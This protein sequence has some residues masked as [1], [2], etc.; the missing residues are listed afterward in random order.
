MGNL[1]IKQNSLIHKPTSP[2]LTLVVSCKGVER[3]LSQHLKCLNRQ[4]LKQELWQ[5]VFLFRED[6]VFQPAVSLIR[7]SFPSSQIFFLKAKQP[8]YEMRNLAFDRVKSPYLYFIDEDVIL[9]DSQHLS[10]LLDLHKKRPGL[11]VLGGSYLNHPES[12]FFGVCYNWLVNLWVKAHK[13]ENCQDL[14]PAGNL[15]VK[16]QEVSQARFYSP[17]GFGSEEIY[18]FKFLHKRGLKSC[19]EPVLDAPHLAR[20]SFKDFIQRAWL[21]GKSQPQKSSADKSLFFKEPAGFLVKIMGLF[22]LLVVRFSLFW[23]QLKLF[24]SKIA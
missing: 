19:A 7:Q 15:S 20:H 17:H 8:I 14:I 16:R 18:F 21:H 23:N 3:I 24:V 9:Q 6:S 1:E 4:N 11:A 22:Y 12:A 10:R 2:L 5:A 13:T